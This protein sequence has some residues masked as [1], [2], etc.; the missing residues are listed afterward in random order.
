MDGVAVNVADVPLHTVAELTLT[1]GTGFTVTVPVAVV[2]QPVSVYEQVYV[3]VDA[4][5]TVMVCVVAPPG[6][7]E[8]VPPPVPGV[9]VSVVDEPAQIVGELTVV[10]LPPDPGTETVYVCEGV[11][12]RPSSTVTV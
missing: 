9:S 6:A 4:G 10:V 5:L 12:V 7:H 11:Q 1:V 8:Y 3:V 2:V